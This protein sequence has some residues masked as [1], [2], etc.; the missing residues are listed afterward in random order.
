MLVM[1]PPEHVTLLG[2][3]HNNLKNLKLSLNIYTSLKNFLLDLGG[4]LNSYIYFT[5]I[6]T[7]QLNIS[8]L[9]M[10][11]NNQLKLKENIFH[12]VLFHPWVICLTNVWLLLSTHR[13][14]SCI[15]W[16]ES[17][18]EPWRTPSHLLTS[19]KR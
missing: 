19:C 3:S 6:I 12:S 1:R 17:L 16:Q 7:W 14:W 15:I 4:S 10:D 11:E 5:T 13:K 18:I 8:I 9:I 2:G